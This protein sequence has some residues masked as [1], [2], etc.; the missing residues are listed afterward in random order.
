[1]TI[2]RDPSQPPIQDMGSLHGRQ[3]GDPQPPERLRHVLRVGV[4]R[5][6]A[7]HHRLGIGRQKGGRLPALAE[8]G[9]RLGGVGAEHVADGC[10]VRLQLLC[11]L[12][13]QEKD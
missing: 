3:A 11:P 5:C 6:E 10:N 2:V 7:L 8:V 4:Q 9:T 12:S 13:L 1:M